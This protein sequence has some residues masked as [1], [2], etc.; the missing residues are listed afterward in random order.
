M[1]KPPLLLL[2]CCLFLTSCASVSVHSPVSDSHQ[3]PAA[4]PS[5]I[6][7][8]DFTAVAQ[9]F[10]VNRS[11]K[12]LRSM[13]TIFAAGL[14]SSLVERFRKHIAPAEALASS[15]VPPQDSAWL[16]T[17]RFDLVNQGSRALRTLLGWGLGGTKLETTVEVFDLSTPP[18]QRFLSFRTTGGS[19]A[20]P[21]M[22]TPPDPLGTPM[23]GLAQATGTGLSLDAKRTARMI[24]ATLSE[25]LASRGIKTSPLRA[26]PLGK[27]VGK[28]KIFEKN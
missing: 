18:P 19:N 28:K 15:S 22:L 14:T 24:T 10:R 3:P 17:G 12:D 9:S 8:R 16:V 13:Q 7:V 2:G 20:Q 4:L 23:C 11:D 25:Y 1:K 21:G 6:Y 26:K 27:L 5:K